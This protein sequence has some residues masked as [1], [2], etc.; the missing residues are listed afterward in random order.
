MNQQKRN[1]TRSGTDID[2]VKRLNQDSGLTYNQVK[3]LLGEQY[4]RKK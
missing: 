2:E 4:S 1:V 3:Q